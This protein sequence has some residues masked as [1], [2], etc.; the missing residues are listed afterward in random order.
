MGGRPSLGGPRFP[1]QGGCVG[2]CACTC[3]C[4]C[5][6]VS[7]RGVCGAVCAPD[8]VSPAL[9][10]CSA[11]QRQYLGQAGKLVAAVPTAARSQAQS[12]LLPPR[13]S[14]P[15]LGQGP[16]CRLLRSSAA[17][18]LNQNQLFRACLPPRP[19]TLL[20]SCLSFLAICSW[21]SPR[22]ASR[23]L[24]GLPGGSI[25]HP[26][27][28]PSP[29]ASPLPWSHQV[30][31]PSPHPTPSPS[32]DSENQLSTLLPSAVYVL[33]SAVRPARGAVLGGRLLGSP[34]SHQ[35]GFG[36]S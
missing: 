11:G 13:F 36:P 8:S 7:Y 17:K 30:P 33:S 21:I 34:P 18:R 35:E 31:L 22:W 6:C 14:P 10:T 28:L 25:A 24:P 26:G 23:G 4:A 1:C 12:P 9:W 20:S 16:V 3:V 29:S 2:A 15:L 27:P 32:P 5:A 19:A